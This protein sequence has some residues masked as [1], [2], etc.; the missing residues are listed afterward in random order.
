MTTLSPIVTDG[1]W[2]QAITAFLLLCCWLYVNL[3]NGCLLYIISCEYSLHTPHYMVLASYMVL[4]IVYCNII[5]SHMITVVISNNIQVM[6]D[7]VSR[8][9]VIACATFHLASVHMTGLFAYERYSYFITPLTYTIKCTVSRIY[10]AI[11]LFMAIAFCISLGVDLVESRIPVATTMMY[12]VTGLASQITNIVFALIYAIPCCTVSVVTLIR[13]S[14]LISKHKA[15]V[16]PTPSGVISEDQSAVSGNVMKPVREALK[17]VALVSG[18]F[19]LLTIPGF[20]IRLGLSASGV[21]W[22]DTDYRVSLPLF[23]LSRASYLMLT[24]LS[25]V[26]NPIIYMTVLTQLREAVWK[27]IGIQ[28]NSDTHN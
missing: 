26:L 12:Q 2:E 7:V 17:M 10:A 11:I 8:A 28:S 23:A 1:P 27:R 21:T 5:L 18:S 4:D 9:V 3:S 15:Q 24:V 14:L 20:M 6:T 22:A 13:L 19:W 16:Q 25:S